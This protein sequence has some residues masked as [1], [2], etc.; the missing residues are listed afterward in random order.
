M[1][2]GARKRASGRYCAEGVW[3]HCQPH[4]QGSAFQVSWWAALCQSQACCSI[5]A[6]R[7]VWR[8]L[9]MLSMGSRQPQKQQLKCRGAAVLVCEQG[10]WF[11]PERM[12]WRHDDPS[13]SRSLFLKLLSWG[14][15]VSRLWIGW[16]WGRWEEAW[17]SH[18]WR[19]LQ[20]LS[21][22]IE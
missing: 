10:E 21:L 12:G 2:W 8:W 3:N 19:A 11:Q 16:F 9:L 22:F 1:L 17:V 6:C 4:P 18:A 15:W 13:W 14:S 7:K 20:K 5:T